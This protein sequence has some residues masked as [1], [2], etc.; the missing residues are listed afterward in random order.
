MCYHGGGSRLM[1]ANIED[2]PRLDR[3]CGTLAE[4][5]GSSTNSIIAKLAHRHL[6]PET[7]GAY[8]QAFGFNTRLERSDAFPL[9][10]AESPAEMPTEDREFA[11]TAAGFWTEM[12]FC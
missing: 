4:A 6:D 2:R 12:R 7:L 5:I 11:R 3:R 9:D 8:A 10:M 1:R